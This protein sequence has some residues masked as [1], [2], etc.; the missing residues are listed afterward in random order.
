MP[1]QPVQP[2]S[3][4]KSAASRPKPIH[5]T[6]P[7][8]CIVGIGAS[9]GGVSALQDF[10]KAMPT[11]IGV[12]FV[13]VQHLAPSHTNFSVP[14]LAA[15]TAMPVTEATQGCS[16]LSNH[17]YLAP[18]D[19][20]V[21]IHRGKLQLSARHD[22]TK[23]HLPIDHFF[24]ALGE[25]CGSRAIGI[26]L[27]GLGTDGALGLKTIA[28]QGGMVLVQDPA[29]AE[30]DNMP[31]SAMA[32]GIANYVLPVKKMP[33]VIATYAHHPYIDQA[34]STVANEGESR[35]T[36]QLLKI[37]KE[38]RG[39]D[40]AGYKR[41]T[42]MRRIE[43]RMGLRGIL[44]LLDYVN[45]LKHNADEVDAL[46]RDLLIGVTEFFRD[47]EAW[48]TLIADVV[49]PVV[50]AKLADEPIRIWIPGC[51]T[52]EEAYTMAMV[53]LDRLRQVRKKCPVQIFATDTNNEALEI[54][55]SGR[56]P[57]SIASRISAAK[58][59]RYFVNGPD[60][61]YY[62][63]N[64]ELRSSV[65]FGVQNL[66]AD[67]PFGRVDMISC[68]NVLIYLEPELQK[69]VLNIFH[70]ALRMNGFLFLG[71]AESNGNRDDIFKPISKKWRIFKRVG[72]SKPDVLALQLRVAESR[73]GLA[74]ALPSSLSPTNQ[75]AS[76]AQKL[77]LDRF[78][79]ASVLI[80]S[81]QH[82]LY[83]CGPTDD[84]LAR[85]RGAP[86][87]DLLAMVREGLR[88]RV[89]AA[90]AEAVKSDL[91][92]TVTGARMKRDNLFVPVQI[93]VTPYSGFETGRLYLVVFW[94]DQQPVLM[95]DKKGANQALV[96]H[97]EEELQ[98]T[99][100]DLQNTIERFE[101][102]NENLKVSNEEVVTTNEELRS[103]NEE[104][105]SSKEE[106]QS[107]NEE[108]ITVNQQLE[109]KV[110]ELEV[111]NNDLNNLL[112][113]S[114]I[115]TICLDRT[116][117]IKWFTPASQ[118][119]F[120]FIASDIGRPISD[121][122]LSWSGEGLLEAASAVLTGKP[123][124]QHEYQNDTGRRF[125]RR[126]LPY[127][128]EGEQIG[129][130]IVTYTDITDS[131]LA[132]EEAS[133]ARKNLS[134][135]QEQSERLRSLASAL[136][137]A[138]VR[139]RRALAQ[140]LHDDLGQL[141]AMAKLKMS[142]VEKL[143]VSKTMRPALDDCS[144]ALDQ[145]NRKLRAMAFQLSP[146][147]LDELGLA[148]AM[149]WMADEVQQMYQLEVHTT[150]DGTPKP[151]EPAVRATLFRAVRELLINVAKHAHVSK[152]NV[153]ITRG[154][155]NM[156]Y[157]TVSDDGTGFDPSPLLSDN[158][159]ANFGLI[160]VRERLTL[161]GGQVSIHS[162]PG[163]GTSVHLQVPLL[164]EPEPALKKK[165]KLEKGQKP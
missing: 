54:G 134:V 96:R 130:V 91:P 84:F 26:I 122:S 159:S 113:S 64:D 115:A 125:I 95:P 38:R 143:K 47:A 32:S 112:N 13:V 148:S 93:S 160:S 60:S 145:A 71:S 19:Q 131:F 68:R 124:V 9:S 23:L 119:Q 128:N 10:F 101:T 109:G 56:Y 37:I 86:T 1:T 73:I 136:A 70:F 75:I 57:L 87:S 76:I 48:K 144:K 7:P 92:I 127:R 133:L 58:L 126:V 123:M 20:T 27:S 17:I 46:F 66:F 16:V 120:K 156:L 36:Q 12:G 153:N 147:M 41:T 51:S 107:L 40:F 161:L 30:Y 149:E 31:R 85:P 141:L 45:L 77:I 137:L 139:E 42:L 3:P 132:A 24:N 116:F 104:L 4:R 135:S 59:K 80:D 103:L 83:F 63:V 44:T 82:A 55:R 33:K 100:D 110:R 90:L 25:D 154:S 162:T 53:V 21:T 29:T 121:F 142:A 11:D 163:E 79:P 34:A 67:P 111:A 117:H 108:L 15:C 78:A 94:H 98:A 114:D 6:L 165:V 138:E 102:T 8:S 72:T 43:R 151:L 65:V 39:Y 18:A 150:Y 157:V 118:A 140:D 129:G 28:A 105:E 35:E 62:M 89:R 74:S 88:S 106:L 81:S 152:A 49:T 22:T 164:Q 61:Q 14:L 2:R 155:D 5:T 52:G 158:S 50:S 97:L 69:R 146:P 99:R